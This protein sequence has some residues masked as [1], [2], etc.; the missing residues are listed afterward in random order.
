M[1]PSNVGSLPSTSLTK[2]LPVLNVLPCLVISVGTSVKSL[3]DPLNNSALVA[4][5]AEIDVK[6]GSVSV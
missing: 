2:L 3:Y 6:I 4:K 1:E 5:V